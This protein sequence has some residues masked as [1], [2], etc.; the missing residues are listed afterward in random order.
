MMK[1]DELVKSLLTVMPDLIRHPEHIDFT[2]FSDKSE[3]STGW[4][5]S[6]TWC[7]AGMTKNQ[8]I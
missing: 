7:G 2:G 3:S 5:L 1:I 8:E 6:R 4:S